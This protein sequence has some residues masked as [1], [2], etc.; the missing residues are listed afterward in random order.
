MYEIRLCEKRELGLLKDFIS[1]CWSKDHVFLKSEELLLFQHGSGDTL[2]FVVAHHVSSNTFHGA[3]GFISASHYGGEVICG[4]DLWLAIWKVDKESSESKNVGLDMLA[5]LEKRYR[6]RR[7]AAIG[8]ND[9]VALLYRLMGFKIG[10]MRQWFFPN[11]SLTKSELIH[12]FDLIS[13]VENKSEPGLEMIDLSFRSKLLDSFFDTNQGKNSKKY[14]I[15]RYAE[16]PIYQYKCLGFRESKEMPC[17]IAIGREV[18]ALGKKA[19]R[20]T[21]FWPQLP[22]SVQINGL[23]LSFLVENNYEYVDFLEFGWNDIPLETQGFI[24]N[25]DEL[26]VPHLFE[27]Y[28]G[29]R[30]SVTIAYRG[31]AGFLCSKGDSDLDRPSRV[32]V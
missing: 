26:Y 12:G 11:Y 21:D 31:Q 9:R 28:V 25:T 1:N 16:H 2:N 27:P 3:L 6:P 29:H 7:I 17:A 32:S 14:L 19:F 24:L 18:E 5:Y 23:L 22:D 4:E 20:I 8:I 30:A 10:Q 15:H 13:L